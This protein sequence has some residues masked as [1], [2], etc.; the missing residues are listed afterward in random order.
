MADGRDPSRVLRILYG[1][2]TGNAEDMAKRIGFQAKCHGFSV[3]VET[4]DDFN[5]KDL[6]KQSL[7][8][9]VC[10]T[11]GHGQEPENMKNLFNFMRRK[12]LPKDCLAKMKYAVYGLGDSSYAKFNYVSKILFKRLK[13]CG[14]QP[15]QELVAG[16][17]QHRFGCDGAIYPKLDELWSKLAGCDIR[18]QDFSANSDSASYSYSVDFCPSTSHDSSNSGTKF[19][20][21]FIKRYNLCEAACILNQRITDPSHF[22]DTRFLCFKSKQDI[23]YEPGDVCTIYPQ[24]P[25]DDV[26]D[27]IKLLNLDPGQRIK[28]KKLDPNFMVNYLY[29]FVPDGL[30][31]E[32]LVRY[33]FDIRSIPK[34]SF[35]ECLW[36]FSDNDLERNKLRELASTEGQEEVYEYCIK[37]KRSI[38]ETLSDF[39]Q[40]IKNIRFESLFDIIP[41]IKPRS[42]SI[43][44][45]SSVHPNEI[46]LIVGVVSYKTDLRNSR[47]ER[48]LRKGLCSNYLANMLH[49]QDV[50]HAPASSLI[51]FFIRRTSFSLPRDMQTPVIMVGPGLG[52]APFRSFIEEIHRKR[53]CNTG[54]SSNGADLNHLYFGC[55]YQDKDFYFKKELEDYSRKSTIRLQV[56]FSRQQPKQYVQDLLKNDAGLIKKLMNNQDGILYV[57]GNSKL[58]EAIRIVLANMLA[59]SGDSGEHLEEG[60]KIVAHLEA[61]NRIQYDCW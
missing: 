10:S 43:A 24:N 50:Q 5:L 29:D 19:N 16:D 36:P 33:Y 47:G 12:D 2:Q 6:P 1:S 58:P 54:E 13:E 61:S 57:A 25:D 52:I 44:S 7:V 30:T 46:H 18:A 35:F 49:V 42:F 31:V 34:R 59:V 60:E 20:D 11:T 4:M 40:T 48:K 37:L 51:R 9:F 17:E 38:L 32:D 53:A 8:I 28:L 21:E 22:Q 39:P 41:P 27:F 55:R 3:I 15:I 45:A 23:Y 26:Q 56:A 14:A